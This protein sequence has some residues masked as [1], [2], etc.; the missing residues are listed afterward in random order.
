MGHI[1]TA[2]TTAMEGTQA[3]RN[4]V[5]YDEAMTNFAI[6]RALWPGEDAIK[7]L[8]PLTSHW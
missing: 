2:W 1:V 6:M 7:K 5:M 3:R 4:E 8:V